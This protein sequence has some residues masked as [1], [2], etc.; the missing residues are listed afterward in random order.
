M[1]DLWHFSKYSYNG[2]I[3]Y[4]IAHQMNVFTRLYLVWLLRNQWKFVWIDAPFSG[5]GHDPKISTRRCPVSDNSLRPPVGPTVFPGARS[6]N[7]IRAIGLPYNAP[8]LDQEQQITI[9]IALLNAALISHISQSAQNW[10]QSLSIHC[11][12]MIFSTD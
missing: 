2:M 12:I 10:Q 9:W 4:K 8:W 7:T 11:R 1:Y 5:R 6:V 3:L